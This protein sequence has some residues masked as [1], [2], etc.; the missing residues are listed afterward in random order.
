M[1]KF[2][3][4]K[5]RQNLRDRKQAKMRVR[6]QALRAT[7]KSPLKTNITPEPAPAKSAK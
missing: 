7:M 5:A 3:G 4:D 2:N 1:S 6:T